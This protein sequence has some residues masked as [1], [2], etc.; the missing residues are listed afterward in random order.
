[1]GT[2]VHGG[3]QGA[4]G[5]EHSPHCHRDG[6]HD[7]EAHTQGDYNYVLYNNEREKTLFTLLSLRWPD[8]QLNEKQKQ[9]RNK[10]NN[11]KQNF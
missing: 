6:Q 5:P 4:A 9:Q 3:T 2:P 1:M 11:S 7:C 8:K 10:N